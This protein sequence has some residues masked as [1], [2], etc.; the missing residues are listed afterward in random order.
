[1]AMVGVAV[2]VWAL[3]ALSVVMAQT[4]LQID[5][6]VNETVGF[7]E[8]VL[9]EPPQSVTTTESIG[10][11]E[12][13]NVAGPASSTVEETVAL[14]DITTLSAL[15]LAETELVAGDAADF[16]AFGASVA[17]SDLGDFVAIGADVSGTNFTGAVYVFEKQGEAWAQ[18]AQLTSTDGELFDR[19]GFAVAISADGSTVVAGAPSED[20]AGDTAGAIYVFD[21]PGGGW[22][23]ATE[24]TKL[25]AGPTAAANDEFGRAVAIDGD[26][27]LV[28]A[29]F[30]DDA[31]LNQGAAYVF[32]RT[33]GSWAL[34]ARLVSSDPGQGEE[35]GYSVDVEF[36][37][38]AVGAA[39]DDDVANNAGAAY[40]FERGGTTWSQKAKL[41]AADAAAEDEL[42]QAL[43]I[44]NDTL[45]VGAPLDDD[46]GADSGSAY[47]F[48]KSGGVWV[49]ATEDA[50]LVAGGAAAGDRFGTSVAIDATRIAVGTPFD[51]SAQDAGSVAVFIGAGADWTQHYRLTGGDGGADDA[52]GGS[53]AI[54]DETVVGGAASSDEAGSDAGETYV[55]NLLTNSAFADLSIVK[56]D[57]ADPVETG[58]NL[59]YTF[60]VSNAGPGSASG[61]TL[62][63][64]L[65]SGVTFVSSTTAGAWAPAP[66]WAAGRFNVPSAISA[67][68]ARPSYRS[69]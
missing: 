4:A 43:S 68:V 45:V 59:T 47:V 57:S 69:M 53:V 35:F 51:D 12:A 64:T 38:A 48:A 5:L 22:A 6:T 40:I 2:T 52:L 56:T 10:L 1:M 63:D 41:T 55:F 13:I 7:G 25:T 20:A 65:P 50:K 21:R 9:V 54:A 61:V 39:R 11:S 44:D 67:A 30:E 60:T 19:L 8:A 16:A 34:Q 58:T 23:N 62:T 32:L 28:G 49:D 26:T 42:G 27:L 37:T 17:I 66:T 36:D 33:G 18:V 3:A 14:T 46:G 31:F 29:P 24:D 15:P